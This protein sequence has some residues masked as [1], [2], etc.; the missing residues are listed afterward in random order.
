MHNEQKRKMKLSFSAI[1]TFDR[2]P[3]K[4]KFGYIERPSVPEKPEFFFGSLL[5][6]IV[7]QALA[8]DPIRVPIEELNQTLEENWREDIFES[9]DQSEDYKNLGLTMIR[10]FHADHTPGLT[11][12]VAIERRFA[13]PL[14]D[15]I[16]TGV[17]DRI[18]KLPYG[19]YE[20]I[21]Y[22]TSTK[23]PAQPDIDRDRQLGIYHLAVENLWPDAKEIRLTLYFLK[24]KTKMTTKRLGSDITQLKDEIIKIAQKIE[25]ATKKDDFPP[26]PNSWCDF[27]EYGHLCP[28]MKGKIQ[29]PKFENQNKKIDKA[30]SEYLKAH[31]KIAEL[32]PV[33]HKHFDQAKIERFFHKDGIITRIGGKRKRLSIRKPE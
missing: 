33:I 9:K 28:M 17:I 6:K 2:C 14:G 7:Q 27:C 26:R 30:I 1:D 3:L 25:K 15:H 12:I 20:V 4:Y 23:L 18:D 16:L 21:D 5:H 10:N 8:K 13:I 22:K 31:K 29:N 11:H 19:P 32:E 24:H